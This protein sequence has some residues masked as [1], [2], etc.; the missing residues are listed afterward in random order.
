MVVIETKSKNMS[1]IDNEHWIKVD[2][3]IHTL[4]DPKDVIDYSAHQLLERAKQLGFGVLAITLHDAVFDRAEVFADAAAMGILLIPAAEVRLQGADAILLNVTAS[5]VAGLKNFEDLR[6]LR[7]RRGMSATADPSGRGSIFTIAPHPFYVLGGSIGPRLLEEID[8][9]DA[10]ELCHFHKGLLNPNRRA[11]KVAAQ[12]S[13]PLIATSDA[14]QLHAFGRHYTSIP[15]STALTIEN[16]FAA[17]RQGP[18]RLTSPPASMVDLASAIYW[19]FLAH[20]FK[21]RRSQHRDR[22]P[23]THSRGSSLESK[24]QT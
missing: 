22:T 10:I 23:S 19:I 20:P 6:Q 18:L 15:R 8:C 3:H 13:K 14:H 11:A 5:E 9:F 24:S 2:L 1:K 16:V 7:A 12:F 17:L 21:L 4:D